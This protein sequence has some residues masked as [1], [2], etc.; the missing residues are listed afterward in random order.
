MA[1]RAAADTVAPFV[2]A[3]PPPT[4]D[5]A[6][7]VRHEPSTRSVAG[8][9]ALP[10][11]RQGGGAHALVTGDVGRDDARLH[12]VTACW[13][14]GGPTHTA[15]AAHAD[16]AA[17]IGTLPHG[18]PPGEGTPR[19]ARN[20]PQRSGRGRCAPSGNAAAHRPRSCPPAPAPN[21]GGEQPPAR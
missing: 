18:G 9:E 7:D 14:A 6:M 16:D 2:T 20:L 3:A 21:T 10:A 5:H 8:R 12:G 1:P 15:R 17:H 11:S 13:G 19:T 4:A